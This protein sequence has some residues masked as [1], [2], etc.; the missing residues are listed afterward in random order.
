MPDETLEHR[1]YKLNLKVLLLET[2][3]KA[4]ILHLSKNHSELGI[5]AAFAEFQAETMLHLKKNIDQRLA[6]EA[7]AYLRSFVPPPASAEID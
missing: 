7:E 5:A 4:V 6:E 1:L 2:A 3:L